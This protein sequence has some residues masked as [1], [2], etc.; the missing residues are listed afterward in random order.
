MVDNV[1][2]AEKQDD[3]KTKAS[4]NDE[5]TSVEVSGNHIYFYN[6]V[7]FETA[8][9]LNKSLQETAIKLLNHNNSWSLEDKPVIHLHINSGGG[10]IDGGTA[11]MDTILRLKDK[12][13]IYTYVEG[14]AASA[15]T[16]ISCVGTKRFITPNSR[17]LIHQ[18]SSGMWGTYGEFEDQKKNLDALMEMIKNIYKKYT[19]VPAKD[20]DEILSHDLF[21]DSK[22]CLELGLVD[23]IR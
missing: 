4:S 7:D 14:R 5:K 20:L 2:G 6:G 9:N 3:K 18:L 10:Y 22:K 15:A 13:D 11:I 23:E 21:W 12:I 1:W 19:D 17:M 8:L 16:F